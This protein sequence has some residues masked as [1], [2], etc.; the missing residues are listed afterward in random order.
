MKTKRV[1][2]LQWT[3]PFCGVQHLGAFSTQYPWA[4]VD[5]RGSFATLSKWHPGCGFSPE[6]IDFDN[7]AKARAAGSRWLNTQ[8]R[9]RA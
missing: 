1:T 8:R 5:D 3:T 4:T 6:N 2:R 7:A 9:N